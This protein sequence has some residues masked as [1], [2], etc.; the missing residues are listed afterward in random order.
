MTVGRSFAEMKSWLAG[1]A[2]VIVMFSVAACDTPEEKAQAHYEAGMA[3]VAEENFAKAGVEFRNALQI[4]ENF[5]DGWYG[6]ALVEENDGNWR[7]YAGNILKA[8]EVDPKHFKAQIRYGKIMLLSGKLQKALETSELVNEL[9]PR[10]PDAL[11]LKAAVLFRLGDKTG[12][13]EAANAALTLDPANVDSVLILAAEKLSKKDPEAAIDILDRGLGHSKGNAQ[14]QVI[15]IRA[16]ETLGKAEEVIQV[17]QELIADNPDNSAFRKSLVRFYLKNGQRDEAEK[18]IRTIAVENPEDVTANLDVVRFVKT[19]KGD[20]AATIELEQLIETHPDVVDYRFAL[21]TLAEAAGQDEKAMVILGTIIDKASAIEDEITAINKLAQLHFVR[22]EY[23]EAWAYAEDAL[24]IDWTSTD[25]L[26]LIGA[27]QIDKG[28]IDAAISTLRSSMRQQPESVRAALLLAKA[29]E[30]NGSHELA[31]DRFAAAYRFS[32]QS[33]RVGLAYAQFFIR[34]GNYSRAERLLENIAKM[35]PTEINALKLLADVKLKEED[36]MA[37][38]KIA[39]RIRA[40]DSMN[41]AAYQISGAALA[42]MRNPEESQEAYKKAYE[43]TPE[44]GQAMAALVQSYL[45][46][47]NIAEAERFLDDALGK[48]ENK[49]LARTLMA[50]IQTHKNNLG[51]A[52]RLLKE[53]ISSD[54]AEASGYV[55]LARHYLSLNRQKEAQDILAEGMESAEDGFMLRITQAEIYESSGANSD[56]IKIYED[57]L[58]ERPNSEIVAN[59]LASLI[60]E[61]AQSDA[62]LQ[63]AY[64]LAKRFRSSKVPYFMDT[65]GW[66]HYRLGEY[67]MATPLLRSAVEKAPDIAILR[68]HLGMAYKAENNRDKALK[69]LEQAVTLADSQPFAAR[70]KAEKAIAELR[71]EPKTN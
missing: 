52:E 44:T 1:L 43:A 51:E 9:A 15:K 28:E 6:L 22:G 26:V 54:P 49:Y 39:D 3:F 53:A 64:A 40:V 12:A 16:L 63:R 69:E 25:A 5:A 62:E 45:R 18:E 71:S 61:E 59:N 33:P 50:Q 11:A 30:I 38:E 31:E 27:M 17:F 21:A 35:K 47:G 57:L 68:Y 10:S 36:W 34:Q 2:L 42:G 48:S 14:L 67:E 8:I 60:T 66:I 7:K 24:E 4:N 29:H 20:E 58:E 23:D 65:L 70:D 32:K 41:A 13:I 19:L 37:A 56:A 55:M 46:G